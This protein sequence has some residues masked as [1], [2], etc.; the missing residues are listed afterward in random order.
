MLVLEHLPRH[1]PITHGEAPAGRC[2]SCGGAYWTRLR[3]F[4]RDGSD[5]KQEDRINRDG[6]L[7]LTSCLPA[8]A[9]ERLAM[10]EGD[11]AA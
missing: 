2:G 9:L 1:R 8:E 5:L 7:H 3:V 11:G 4:H 6:S 10:L